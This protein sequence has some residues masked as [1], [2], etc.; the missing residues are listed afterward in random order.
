MEGPEQI[1]HCRADNRQVELRA[2]QM[3][4]L[5]ILLELKRI[6]QENGI[7][8]FLTGG[9]LLGAVRH[10]GFIPWDDDIDVAMPRKDFD[11][12]ACVCPDALSSA[13]FYQS[14]QTE[15]NYPHY[16]AKIRKCGTYAGEPVTRCIQM[17]QGIFIDIFPLDI[18]PDWDSFAKLFFKGMQLLTCAVLARSSSEFICGYKKR[19][20]RLLWNLLRRLPNKWLFVLRDW[21]RKIFGLAASGRLICNVSGRYG[22]PQEVCKTEWFAQKEEL[23]FEKHRFFAPIGW[24]EL[25]TTVYGDYMTPLD[26]ADRQGHFV[27]QSNR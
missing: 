4:E 9:T 17:E 26:E 10:N 24:H 1:P 16:Y 18:C 25:L 12:F 20:M 8:Y 27:L 13:Y 21:L 23:Q 14:A 11:R 7:N 6:C 3:E 2:I 5:E 19:Y 15:E 22:F